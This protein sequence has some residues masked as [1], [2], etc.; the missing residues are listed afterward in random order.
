MAGMSAISQ[1]FL[2]LPLATSVKTRTFIQTDNWRNSESPLGYMTICQGPEAPRKWC[3]D[4]GWR[5]ETELSLHSRGINQVSGRLKSVAGE[6]G[7]GA[8]GWQQGPA[9][10]TSCRRKI[11]WERLQLCTRSKWSWQLPGQLFLEEELILVFQRNLLASPA[12]LPRAI[13]SCGKW[14]QLSQWECSWTSPAPTPS[15]FYLSNVYISRLL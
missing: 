6:P 9:P 5:C 11:L 15:P 8:P 14:F 1:P 13:S 2:F 10:G 7:E 3:R 4:D 12:L